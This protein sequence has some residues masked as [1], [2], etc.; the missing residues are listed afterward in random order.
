MLILGICFCMPILCCCMAQCVVICI[1]SLR[2]LL[3]CI[4]LVKG[5][6]KAWYAGE[7]TGVASHAFLY[8]VQIVI[9]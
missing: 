9:V 7:A 4:S 2:G 5:N 3:R 8:Y 6:A 1:I